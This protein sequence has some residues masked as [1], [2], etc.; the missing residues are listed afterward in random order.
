MRKI[1]LTIFLL[2]LLFRIN[3]QEIPST[4]NAFFSEAVG[5]GLII[6]VNYERHLYLNE[7]L[8]VAPKIGLG[9][10]IIGGTIPHGVT[11]NYGN[12]HKLEVGIGGTY[13]AG[14]LF[15][16]FEGYLPHGILGYRYQKSEGI[17]FRG[18]LTPIIATNDIYNSS[19]NT[20]ISRT[21]LFWWGGISFGVNF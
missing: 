18:T 6:S 9:W 20:Y 5:S 15:E 11:I 4:K 3:A 13:V 17:I 2:T 14:S 12:R 21:E 7:S 16:N 19:T 8:F 1:L 10:I